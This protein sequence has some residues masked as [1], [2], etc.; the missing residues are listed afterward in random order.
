MSDTN[1]PVTPDF[2]EDEFSPHDDQTSGSKK[3]WIA[4]ASL[5]CGVL[6]LCGVAAAPLGCL[7]SLAAIVL[8]L[9]GLKSNLRVPAIIGLLMGGLGVILSFIF[10]LVLVAGV[11]NT[12]IGYQIFDT[13]KNLI[14]NY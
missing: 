5:I 4:I 13:I 2:P 1:I 14:N 3:N 7:F 6:S 9:I 10:G 11:S 8:G 12:E